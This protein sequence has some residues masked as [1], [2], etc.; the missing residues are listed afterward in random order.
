[1]ECHSENIQVK[2]KKK[3]ARMKRRRS[4]GINK[5][6]EAGE[7][8]KLDTWYQ[9]QRQAAKEKISANAIIHRLVSEYL[10][11]VK[12]KMHWERDGD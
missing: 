5:L 2:R 3:E 11:Q 9:L 12:Q 10:E 4:N 8:D 6:H 7:D 1:M